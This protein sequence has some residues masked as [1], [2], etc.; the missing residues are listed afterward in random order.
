MRKLSKRLIPVETEAAAAVTIFLL[1]P[2]EGTLAGDPAGRMLRFIFVRNGGTFPVAG[3][4]I[5]CWPRHW[6]VCTPVLR[7]MESCAGFQFINRLFGTGFLC[8]GGI[9]RA[10]IPANRPTRVSSPE[11]DWNHLAQS[12]RTHLRKRD[13]GAK[14]E[15]LGGSLNPQPVPR[16]ATDMFRNSL[17]IRLSTTLFRMYTSKG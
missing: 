17:K 4:V 16:D 7:I 12:L 1:T 9:L 2:H 8:G 6:A 13:L 15:S 10:R 5:S 11:T 3:T 14:C